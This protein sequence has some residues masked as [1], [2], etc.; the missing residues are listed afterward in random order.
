MVGVADGSHGPTTF[1]RSSKR[2]GRDWIL[3]V[4]PVRT[5]VWIRLWRTLD[6][7]VSDSARP[8]LSF[9]LARSPYEGQV[10]YMRHMYSMY[11]KWLLHVTLRQGSIAFFSQAWPMER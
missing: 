9:F 2:L 11:I 4:R 8:F 6:R 3:A 7:L 10:E 5:A 1:I